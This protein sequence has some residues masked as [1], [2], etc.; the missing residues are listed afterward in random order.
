MLL[1]LLLL[2]AAAWWYL[3]LQSQRERA[4]T[5]QNPLLQVQDRSGQNFARRRHIPPIL[6]LTGLAFMLMGLSRPEM[7][8][9]LPR[10][11]GTVILAF[12]VSNSMLAED[13]EPNRIEEIGRAHV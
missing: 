2:P 1:S 5:A 7:V 10:V 3:R 8:V 6:F 9:A 13:F 11:E 12:D 4:T